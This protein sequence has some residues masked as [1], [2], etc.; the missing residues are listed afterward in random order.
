M[1]NKYK[2][3]VNNIDDIFSY[4]YVMFDKDYKLCLIKVSDDKFRIKKEVQN[5]VNTCQ[6][7]VEDLEAFLKEFNNKYFVEKIAEYRHF[8]LFEIKRTK[9]LNMVL[10]KSDKIMRN[11]DRFLLGGDS[12]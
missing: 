6:Y 7:N 9:N 12:D 3:K 2:L 10:A 8:C 1:L 4:S 11:D 5:F